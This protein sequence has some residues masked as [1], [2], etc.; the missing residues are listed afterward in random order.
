MSKVKVHEKIFRPMIKYS[1]ISAAIDSVADSLNRDFKDYD[2]P[3]TLLCVLNGAMPFTCELMR[4]LEFDVVLSSIKAT[5]YSGTDST[6]VVNLMYCGDINSLRDKTVIICE[7]IV[8]TGTTTRRMKE[9]LLRY[10][11]KDVRICTMLLKPQQFKNTLIKQGLAPEG[12]TDEQASK[13]YPEYV[14]LHIGDEFIVG[15]GLDYN[16]LGRQYKDIYVLD[17]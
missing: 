10:G 7:D 15:F 11:A 5:S 17:E 12:C 14:G 9:E 8:D 6:G 3:P 13:M 2:E 4:R 16:E 1:E